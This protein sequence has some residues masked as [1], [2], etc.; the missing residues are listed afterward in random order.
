MVN[1]EASAVKPASQAA[2]GRALGLSPASMTK[3]KGQGMPVDSVASA[4][5]WREARQNL[6]Q[7]KP[8]LADLPPARPVREA[9]HIEVGGRPVFGGGGGFDM[10]PDIGMGEDRDE[11]RTRREIADANI[12]EMEE[13]RMRRELIRVSAV[14]AQMSVDFATTRDA[15][16]QIPARMGPLLAA[17]SDTAKVQ[18]LLHAEIHQALLDL[19]G[20]SDRV[21][22]IEGAFD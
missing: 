22:Q 11:A 5:A 6:A 19:A 17:E 15:L 14:Q 18:N 8:A 21:E 2:I 13:A 3:L 10:P 7:R 1:G 20:A 16:L 4:Q 9:E 12:A